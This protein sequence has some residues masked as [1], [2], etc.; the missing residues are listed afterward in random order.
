[1]SGPPARPSLIGCGRPGKAMGN[2]PSATPSAMPMKNGMK[3]VSLSSLS[4]LPTAAAALSR[5]ALGADDLHLVAK[6]QAQA[7]HGGH[8]EIGAGDARNGD[9]EAVVEIEFVNSFTEH[10]AVSHDY[11]AEGER[12]VGEHEVFVAALADNALKLIEP[13]AGADDGETVVAMN[14]GRVGGSARF[15]AVADAGDSNA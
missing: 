14:Y 15:L 1:M 4:E 9:T 12:A 2:V 6:L 8:L 13:R 11:A 7:G 3:C 10:S 5:S